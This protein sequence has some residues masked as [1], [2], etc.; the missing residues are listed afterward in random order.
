MESSE[1]RRYALP[2][3]PL[4]EN[5]DDEDPNSLMQSIVDTSLGSWQSTFKTS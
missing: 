4:V 1:D 3:P 5:D 2:T